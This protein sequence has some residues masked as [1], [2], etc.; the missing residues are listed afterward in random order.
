MGG[1]KKI[2]KNKNREESLLR[3][4]LDPSETSSIVCTVLAL[5]PVAAILHTH[6]HVIG[7]F[8]FVT[9]AELPATNEATLRLFVYG[10]S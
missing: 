5:S 9:K 2:A 3:Y 6:S 1:L 10:I 7:L 4:K 8:F